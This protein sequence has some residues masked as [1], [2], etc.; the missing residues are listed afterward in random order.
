MNTSL[1]KFTE[2]AWGNNPNIQL[3]DDKKFQLA[4]CFASKSILEKETIYSNIKLKFLITEVAMSITTTEIYHYYERDDSLICT[5]IQ[6]DKTT[7]EATTV[8]IKNYQNS[9]AKTVRLAK[10]LPKKNLF[11]I[12]ILPDSSL[13]GR[14]DLVK[15]LTAQIDKNVPVTRGLTGD[16]AN[17]N[18]T[19]T[20]LNKQPKDGE[21][22]PISFYGN[23]LT[24]THQ[25]LG[26]WDTFGLKK[27]FTNSCENKLL[28]LENQ[29]ALALQKKYLD[30]ESK[31]LPESGLL[32]PLSVIIPGDTK[33]IIQTILSTNKKDSSMSFARD[34]P[35][36]S[37]VRFMK[38]NFTF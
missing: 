19:L 7:I 35:I 31:K 32:F 36:G 25:S 13:V 23:Y 24:M 20:G 4:L 29:N 27:K 21:I 11:H 26:I 3:I 2:K 8:H 5:A 34:V 30:S 18:G 9:Y 22:I 33:P 1:Y 17:F 14:S 28:K 16:D 15:G 12:L 37:K 10:K 6:F 38:A